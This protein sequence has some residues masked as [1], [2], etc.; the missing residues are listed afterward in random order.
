MDN[1][2]FEIITEPDQPN[3]TMW[4]LAELIEKLSRNGPFLS[5]T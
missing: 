3:T 5:T 1:F 4:R 2:Y